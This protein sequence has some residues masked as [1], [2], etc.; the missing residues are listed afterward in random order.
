[1]ARE[2]HELDMNFDFAHGCAMESDAA[3]VVDVKT[4]APVESYVR[5]EYEIESEVAIPLPNELKKY[6]EIARMKVND[7]ILVSGEKTSKNVMKACIR[8]ANRH[9][10]KFTS[11][12]VGSGLRI[13]RIQ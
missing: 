7:S 11:R 4:R 8:H 13:W 9:G 10:K 2:E 3:K 6:P 1:M 5:K 12:R